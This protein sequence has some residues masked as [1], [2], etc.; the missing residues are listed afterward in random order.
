MEALYAMTHWGSP[1]GLGLFLFFAGCGAGIL[2]WGISCLD[3]SEKG[4]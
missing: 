2:L 4:K 3:K 1:I